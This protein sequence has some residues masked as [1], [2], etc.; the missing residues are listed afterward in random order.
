MKTEINEKNIKNFVV[1]LITKV[2]NSEI[3][4]VYPVLGQNVWRLGVH[5]CMNPNGDI[6][7]NTDSTVI[8]IPKENYTINMKCL[9]NTKKYYK[10]YSNPY[11]KFITQKGAFDVTDKLRE[12]ASYHKY[13][14]FYLL[15]YKENVFMKVPEK[16]L[17]EA[18]RALHRSNFYNIDILHITD[19]KRKVLW[20]GYD[21]SI[22]YSYT[23]YNIDETLYPFEKYVHHD[24]VSDNNEYT[25][26]NGHLIFV[27]CGSVER[28]MLM[29]HTTGKV[30]NNE[31][32]V[33]KNNQI[34]NSFL[35]KVLKKRNL[36]IVKMVAFNDYRGII[37]DENF[38]KC[39]KKGSIQTSFITD[40]E[41]TDI[42]SKAAKSETV[43]VIDN[44]RFYKL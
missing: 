9:P 20:G 12:M 2:N 35:H 41:C 16:E 43:Q 4:K 32:S 10:Q 7:R 36:E 37:N 39:F 34:Y 18:I 42:L 17:H 40:Y 23:V 3:Y 29:Y 11:N 5:E 31:Q 24:E 27:K 8:A 33:I 1:V 21:T 13:M 30:E 44:A 15:R 28:F 25:H 38:V 14:N 19:D 26:K 22:N 6:V